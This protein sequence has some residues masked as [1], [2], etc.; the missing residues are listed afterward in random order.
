MLNEFYCRFDDI[1]FGEEIRTA[2]SELR[3]RMGRE[4]EDEEDCVVVEDHTR[5]LFDRLNP[6]KAMGPDGICCRL[7]KSCASQLSC[8]QQVV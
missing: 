5:S 6:R 1:D 8:V 4:G 2:Q 3:R 7:L